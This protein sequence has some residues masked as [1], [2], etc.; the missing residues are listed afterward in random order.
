MERLLLTLRFD[1]GAYHGWQVQD[2]AMTVQQALQDAIER[3]TGVRAGVIG[4]SRTDAGVHAD[5]FC[6]TFDTD[7]RLRGARMVDALNYHLPRDIA[8]YGCR[9][10]PPGFHPRYDAAGKRYRYHI[11]NE[12]A[13]HPVW[14]RYALHETRPV[15]IAPLQQA[16]DAFCG[17][18]DFAAFCA[19]GSDV[20]G[21]VRTVRECAI[22]REGGLVTVT[23][24][25]DGFL[26]NMVRILVGTLLDMARGRLDPAGMEA[27]LASRDRARA[28]YT[29]PPHG[30]WLT[31][32]FYPKEA[33]GPAA[34]EGR[35]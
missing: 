19:A 5:Q 32:V 16:A 8:V 24:A 13:R 11:W 9:A 30:L 15:D 18:H 14:A 26:Y 22:A 12:R 10:V 21:T 25:A 20:V 2:N 35:A 23:V 1:G 31:D 34:D 28:G 33:F 17:T 6:C 7:S 3:V 29:A 27:I 4:C